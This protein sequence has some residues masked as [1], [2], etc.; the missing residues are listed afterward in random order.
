[1]PSRRDLIRM[2]D[3]EVRSFLEE[4]RIVI[5]A[6]HG[7]RGWPHVMPL[8]YIVR[9]D[10]ILSWTYEK[11]QKI[12]NVERDP[13]ATCVVETGGEYTEMRGVQVEAHTTLHRD[14]DF[15]LGFVEELIA[16]YSDGFTQMKGDPKA[17][18]REQA[19]KRTVMEFVPERTVS[20]DHGKL[21]GTY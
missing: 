7:H 2:T 15:C 3:E 17:D 19:A 6:T 12:R 5:V 9:G 14:D 18:L 1:M 10:R 8:W 4:Q 16:R 20:W 13:R 21:G 11:S